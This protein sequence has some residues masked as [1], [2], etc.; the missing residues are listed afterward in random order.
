MWKRFLH[1]SLASGIVFQMC[2]RVCVL[3]TQSCPT[4]FD[5]M[6][7]NPPG[8]SV[9]GILQARVLQWV[10][11]L[12]SRESSQLRDWNQVSCIAGWFFTIWATREAHLWDVFESLLFL[13]VCMW[14]FFSWGFQELLCLN[15][16]V[17]DLSICSFIAS[18]WGKLWSEEIS[19]KN[20][21]LRWLKGG[22][23]GELLINE[24]T[25]LVK[26]YMNS[27]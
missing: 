22:V 11:I 20:F 13:I 5:P 14:F 15:A 9:H 4:L 3:V 18:S 16:I 23:T 8:S 17:I 1:Y 6:D 26:F 25:V 12:F 24:H 19:E 21:N 2:V 27:A 10:A 7:C